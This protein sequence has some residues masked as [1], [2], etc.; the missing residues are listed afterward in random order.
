MNQNKKATVD[1]VYTTPRLDKF[2]A[3]TY[4]ISLNL[5]NPA[6]LQLGGLTTSY[7]IPF[8]KSTAN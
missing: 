2:L 7:S 4:S 5:F 8:Q 1:L 3:V 6:F